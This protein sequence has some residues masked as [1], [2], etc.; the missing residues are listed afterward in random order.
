MGYNQIA[1][2]ALSGDLG[3]YIGVIAGVPEV[4]PTKVTADTAAATAAMNAFE[5]AMDRATR[6]RV[7]RVT[8]KGHLEATGNVTSNNQPTYRVVGADGVRTNNILFNKGGQ[9]PAFNDGGLIPGRPPGDPSVDNL[10]A[11]VDGKGLIKVRSK[12]FIQPEPAV[13]YYGLD[14]MEAIRTL[15][16]PKFNMGGSPGGAS[17]NAIAAHSRSIVAANG[18]VIGRDLMRALLGRWMASCYRRREIIRRMTSP[19]SISDLVRRQAGGKPAL[20]NRGFCAGDR[21][22]NPGIAGEP[23]GEVGR[24]HLVH[25]VHL[26]AAALAGEASVRQH[27]RAMAQ[28]LRPKRVEGVDELSGRNREGVSVAEE[29]ASHFTL[30]GRR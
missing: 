30:V 25:P 17:G 9:V 19:F 11:K 27:D 21:C 18:A 3:R 1:V 13:D 7:Q 20:R 28:G 29:A 6:D 5:A 14:A 23:V 22:A 2:N 15:R 16:M 10:M 8:F 24:D 26:L 12:E 4:K